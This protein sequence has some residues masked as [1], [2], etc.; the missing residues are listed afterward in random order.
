MSCILRTILTNLKALI[1]TEFLDDDGLPRIKDVAI[2]PKFEVVPVYPAVQLTDGTIEVEHGDSRSAVFLT[3]FNDD[4]RPEEGMLD[5]LDL[6]TE[7]KNFIRARFNRLC[8]GVEDFEVWSSD[9]QYTEITPSEGGAA[10]ALNLHWRT[11][12]FTPLWLED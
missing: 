7:L 8:A 10:P 12:R 11:L 9:P 4:P 5:L 3:V 2:L 1:Q 6:T